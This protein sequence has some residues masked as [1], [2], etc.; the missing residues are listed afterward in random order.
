LHDRIGDNMD[1]RLQTYRNHL[2]NKYV[3]NLQKFPQFKS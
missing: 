1:C 2:L 3:I